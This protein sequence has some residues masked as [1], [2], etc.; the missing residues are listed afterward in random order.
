MAVGGG[1][2]DGGA[3]GSGGRVHGSD[4]AMLFG[5]SW[6]FLMF[7]LLP[8]IISQVMVEADLQPSGPRHKDPFDL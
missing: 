1:G 7:R 4:E 5:M 8:D 2:S 6:L 3:G